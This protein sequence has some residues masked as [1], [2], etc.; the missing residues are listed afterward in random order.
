MITDSLGERVQEGSGQR[1]EGWRAFKRIR[2]VEIG[3]GLCSLLFP[4][5]AE[6]SDE[7]CPDKYTGSHKR[8]SWFLYTKQD[9]GHL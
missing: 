5:I 3:W 7:A 6:R 2:V 4:V 1:W 8:K 9:F